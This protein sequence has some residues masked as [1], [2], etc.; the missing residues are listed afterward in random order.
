MINVKITCDTGNTWS[1]GINTSFA[2]A[3]EY[4]L[5]KQFTRED[6]N[7]NEIVD[8]VIIVELEHP[9]HGKYFMHYDNGVY[10]I[11][12]NGVPTAG[13]YGSLESL[14]KLKGLR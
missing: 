1:T 2:G 5:G 14:L 11:T 7:G 13:G 12:R 3:V 8:T 9:K 6:D 10:C 4:F